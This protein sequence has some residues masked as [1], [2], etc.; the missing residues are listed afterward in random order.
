MVFAHFSNPTW[1]SIH[2]IRPI[3]ISRRP[4]RQADG[5]HLFSD[6]TLK[7]LPDFLMRIRRAFRYFGPTWYGVLHEDIRKILDEVGPQPRPAIAR[8]VA[9]A[10]HAAG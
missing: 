8:P 2:E 10:L 1:F 3:W 4:L 6:I 9:D 5:N 7:A